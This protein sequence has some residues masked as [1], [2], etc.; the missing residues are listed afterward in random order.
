MS[1]PS[2]PE[3]SYMHTTPQGLATARNA[4]LNFGGERSPPVL[5]IDDDEVPEPA[6]LTSMLSSHLRFPLPSSRGRYDR[7]LPATLPNWAPDGFFWRRCE[8]ADGQ[9]IHVPIG[10]GNML[11]PPKV[12]T[13]R[14][15]YDTDFDLAGGQ[16]THFLLR[17]LPRMKEL[18]GQRRSGGDRA[19]SRKV[20]YR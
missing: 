4:A 2:H 17:W 7:N 5:F 15:R 20:A 1:T 6:W 14:Q 12:T 19:Y 11:F 16:D 18:C 10:D 13:G 8:H 3:A 9:S